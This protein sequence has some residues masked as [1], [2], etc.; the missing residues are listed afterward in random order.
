MTLGASI[1]IG[2]VVGITMAYIFDGDRITRNKNKKG[3]K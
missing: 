3:G 1:A 2:I